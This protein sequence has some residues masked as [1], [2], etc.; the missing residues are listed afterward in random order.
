MKILQ[1]SPKK[2]YPPT[3]GRRNVPMP[4]RVFNLGD[5]ILLLE[6][7]KNVG[8]ELYTPMNV[9]PAKDRVVS[10]HGNSYTFIYLVLK[11]IG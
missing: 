3:G 7:A 8:L 10:W 2:P 6:L 1:I 11:N 4:W 9:P 5:I